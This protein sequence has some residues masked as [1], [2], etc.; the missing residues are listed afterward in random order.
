[1]LEVFCRSL[2]SVKKKKINNWC[3]NGRVSGQWVRGF[4]GPVSTGCS[5]CQ[6][7]VWST[8]S[9]SQKQ[10]VTATHSASRE[11]HHKDTCQPPNQFIRSISALI[12][13]NLAQRQRSLS[14]YCTVCVCVD[15]PQW[16]KLTTDGSRCS[17]GHSVDVQC[18]LR[19][20]FLWKT[21]WCQEVQWGVHL[22]L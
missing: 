10:P 21:E 20:S 19:W 8:W 4:V 17:C 6:Q 7:T 12:C 13:L 14:I 2:S 1:M 22:C 11:T 16:H 15:L 5:L 3:I 9:W 18:E